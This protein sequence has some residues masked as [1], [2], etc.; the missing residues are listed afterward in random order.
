M[1]N[2]FIGHVARLYFWS[3]GITVRCATTPQKLAQAYALRKRVQTAEGYCCRRGYPDEYDLHSDIIVAY[4]YGIPVGCLRLTDLSIGALGYDLCN[5]IIPQGIPFGNILECRDLVVDPQFR[6]KN[7]LV[8][9]ALTE[10]AYRQSRQLGYSHWYGL[11]LPTQLRHFS[12]FAGYFQFL[13]KGSTTATLLEKRSRDVA[14]FLKYG[15]QLQPFLLDLKRVSY[16]PGARVLFK[17]MPK[18]QRQ[19]VKAEMR[20][21]RQAA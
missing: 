18:K 14:Y 17:G 2:F 4:H 5:P 1:T 10:F 16:L 20:E 11:A 19:L 9:L 12:K 15:E 3:Q 6:S 13:A 7:S 8:F 21:Q